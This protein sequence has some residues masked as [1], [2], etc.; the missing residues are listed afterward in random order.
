MGILEKEKTRIKSSEDK[1]LRKGAQAYSEKFEAALDL[2]LDFDA[3]GVDDIK[4]LKASLEK[5]GTPCILMTTK[6]GYQSLLDISGNLIASSY[7]RIKTDQ[8]GE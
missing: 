1:V 3:K 8:K 4:D 6:Y 7:Y 5:T 2:L